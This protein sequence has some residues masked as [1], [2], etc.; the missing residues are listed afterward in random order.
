V[1]ELSPFSN[2]PV[3]LAYFPLYVKDKI[4]GDKRGKQGR[5]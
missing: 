3:F 5:A 1:H 4:K 2:F